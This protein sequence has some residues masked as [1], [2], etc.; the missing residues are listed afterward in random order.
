[1]AA[2]V[3]AI[4]TDLYPRVLVSSTSPAFSLTVNNTASGNYSLKVM[5]IVAVIA[6]AV[7]AGLPGLV[8]L[9]I[10]PPDQRGGL[11]LDARAAPAGRRRAA[12]P[13]LAATGSATAMSAADPQAAG[14][15]CQ[16]RAAHERPPRGNEPGSAKH[17]AGQQACAGREA[18]G[19]PTTDS[20]GPRAPRHRWHLPHRGGSS[21][22]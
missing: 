21:G 3:L 17:G 15:A 20:A 1:M 18:T 2:S 7:R 10:P 5:T 8:V 13:A 16:R 9:R 11:R 22:D 12:G 14:D 6:A 4:F 19:T